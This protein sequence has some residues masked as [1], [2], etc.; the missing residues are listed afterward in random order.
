QTPW[1]VSAPSVAALV[2]CLQPGVGAES[3]SRAHQLRGWAA[4][5][6]TGLRERGV[7]VV[8]SA[9]PYVLARVGDGVHAA[10]RDAGI[11]V[12][13]ADTFPGLDSSWVRI[14]ARPVAMTELLLDALDRLGVRA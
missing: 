12:R 11:A 5:L 10:L 1:S 7:E 3:L 2:A 13:R 14:A 8:P 9:A 4:A 6:E